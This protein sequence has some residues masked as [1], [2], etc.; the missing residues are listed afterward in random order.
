MFPAGFFTP[1]YW[2]TRYWPK[3]GATSTTAPRLF[4]V[5]SSSATRLTA[6]G[7]RLVTFAVTGQPATALS[8][9]GRADTAIGASGRRNTVVT[10]WG[11]E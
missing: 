5:Q 4:A 8:R 3:V 11:S 10:A 9:A 6:Y 1:R 2:A 7:Q